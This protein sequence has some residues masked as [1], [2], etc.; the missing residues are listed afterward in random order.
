MLKKEHI[1]KFGGVTFVN[2]VSE[3]EINKFIRDLP[4]D[5]RDSL[6]EVTKE[7]RDAGLIELKPGQFSTIDHDQGDEQ[8]SHPEM[9]TDPYAGDGTD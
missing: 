2:N 8:E 1:M 7:L 5:K 9:P 6:A 3:E 4:D